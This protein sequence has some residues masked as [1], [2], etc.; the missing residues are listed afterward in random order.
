MP[1]PRTVLHEFS[2][3]DSLLVHRR[4]VQARTRRCRV[5]W[6]L[7]DGQL[8]FYREHGDRCPIETSVHSVADSSIR[9][10]LT[11]N[12]R[13]EPVRIRAIAVSH[14]SHIGEMQGLHRSRAAQ[15]VCH[16]EGGEQGKLTIRRSHFKHF[17]STEPVRLNASP[18]RL[19][20]YIGL[21]ST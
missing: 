16:G 4:I 10:N 20:V 15:Y 5:L 11:S 3:I 7:V 21:D 13:E 19:A 9:I 1:W 2:T 17:K 18:L 14:S 8:K 6:A 12:F